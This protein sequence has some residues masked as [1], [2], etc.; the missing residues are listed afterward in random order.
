MDYYVED[1]SLE[2]RV[3]IHTVLSPNRAIIVLQSCV[4]D[5][6]NHIYELWYRYLDRVLS[7][8]T[9]H[10]DGVRGVSDALL[11][12]IYRCKENHGSSEEPHK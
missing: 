11:V 2:P 3:R 1:V 8:E 4:S 7:M 9:S 6:S 5:I 10:S 12:G